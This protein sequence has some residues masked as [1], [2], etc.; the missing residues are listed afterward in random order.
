M[1]KD[2][3]RSSGRMT[4]IVITVIICLVGGWYLGAKYGLRLPF[5]ATRGVPSSA[6]AVPENQVQGTSSNGS[7]VA[8]KTVQW[9]SAD[10]KI[11][12]RCDG[13][14]KN[15]GGT[16]PYCIGKNTLSIIDPRGNKTDIDIRHASSSSDVPVFVSADTVALSSAKAT[17]L[18]GYGA[19][20]CRTQ[21]TCTSESLDNLISYAYV[22][23]EDSPDYRALIHY[24]QTGTAVWNASGKKAAFIPNTC[25]AGGCT[26]QSIKGYDLEKDISQS[27]TTV[28]AVG[29]DDPNADAT[30]PA[31]ELLARWLD[32]KWTDDSH[33]SA[34]VRESDGSKKVVTAVF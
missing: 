2:A 11:I 12:Q 13:E 17:I 19:D 32:V 21:G 25:S 9:S 30:D 34:T 10:Y 8:T 31:G 29:S 7:I 5:Q 33:L 20:A 23:G 28:V 6:N 18:I 22:A 3:S 26:M 24:P 14:I 16:A 1:T 27:L 15:A 4:L